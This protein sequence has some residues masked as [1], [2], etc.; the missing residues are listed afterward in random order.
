MDK[1]LIL[2]LLLLAS[3]ANNDKLHKVEAKNMP[4][5]YYQEGKYTL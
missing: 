3:C 5:I 1:V 4:T 2:V